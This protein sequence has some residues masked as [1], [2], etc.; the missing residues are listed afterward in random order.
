MGLSVL[1]S[2]GGFQTAPELFER[3]QRI[4]QSY[5]ALLDNHPLM[6]GSV[7][8]DLTIW[9]VRALVERLTDIK[10]N[11]P[12]LDSDAKLVTYMPKKWKEGE[13]Y[14]GSA[15]KLPAEFNPTELPGGDKVIYDSLGNATLIM[16]N[17]G[18]FYDPCYHPLQKM[19]SLDDVQ[20]AHENFDVYADTLGK[21]LDI[22]QMCD[23]LGIQDAPWMS[24]ETYR[25][26]VK[27]YHKRLFGH[28]KKRCPLKTLSQHLRRHRITG[29]TKT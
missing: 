10:E 1:G 9:Q 6:A 12:A 23:D 2:E 18:F 21:H 8:R 4:V 25:N 7:A 26:L 27:P 3:R 16:P 19:T 11:E 24:P 15:V 28:I 22:I 14:D 29:N 20:Q 13:A 5:G 17:G